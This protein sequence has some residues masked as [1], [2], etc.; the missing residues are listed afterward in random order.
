MIKKLTIIIEDLSEGKEKGYCATVKEL[1]NSVIMADSIGEIFELIPPL[2]D[3]AK[4]NNI[5]KFKKK[6]VKV[7]LLEK[8][9]SP[10]A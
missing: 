4:R 3:S 8:P 9:F 10:V 2:L 1:G 6:I 7:K 5:G